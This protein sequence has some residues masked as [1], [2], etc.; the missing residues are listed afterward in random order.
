MK[1]LIIPDS[2]KNCLPAVQVGHYIA[3]GIKKAQQDAHVEVVPIADGGEGTVDALV[4]AMEGRKV[5]TTVKDA[6]MRDVEAVFGHVPGQSIGIIEM[7]Q[8]SGIERLSDSERNPMKASTYGTGQLIK[9]ALDLGCKSLIIGIG[10]SATNDGGVGMARALGIRFFNDK[11][12]ELVPEADRMGEINTVDFSGVDARINH[13]SIKVAC[14]VDNLLYG[15]RGASEVFGSQKGAAPQMVEQLDSGLKHL[16]LLLK[17]RYKIDVTQLKGGGAAGGLGAG[18]AGF[19]NAELVPGFSLIASVL[20]LEQKIKTSDVVITAEGAV[21]QQ[22]LF[23]KT[24]AGVGRL[25]Q[26]HQK[27]LFVFA[28]SATDESTDFEKAGITALVPITRRPIQIDKAIKNAPVWLEQA[29][30]D[31]CRVFQAGLNLK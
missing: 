25:A 8:A 22:T 17:E 28:G 7:A 24:P 26:K 19:L 31:F 14:D 13:T 21:D 23:G 6:L 30:F 16:G 11:G 4:E 15:P 2:L 18:L 27:P 10:G 1:Y 20:T 5:K 29:A 3:Q 9:A 12:K